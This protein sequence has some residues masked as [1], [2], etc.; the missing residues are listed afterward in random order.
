MAPDPVIHTGDV[1]YP[2]GTFCDYGEKFF[3][4]YAG[5]L[6]VAP[7]FPTVGNHDLASADGGPYDRVFAL[8]VDEPGETRRR[9][10][11]TY[12]PL[13]VVVVDSE[14]YERGDEAEIA[15]Q[16]SWLEEVLAA[17][18]DR[19]WTIVVVHHPP[20]TSLVGNDD[21][22]IRSDLAPV[23]ARYGV[24]LV[25]SGDVHAY[26][27]FHPVDGVTY[28]VTGGG[29]AELHRE[30]APGPGTT[31][32]ASVYHAVRIEAGPE[33]LVLEAIDRDGVVFDRVE[34]LADTGDGG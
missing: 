16:V 9:Y 10:A 26:E 20:F 4:P 22:V 14:V 1:V 30:L 6:A 34:L 33:Q 24:D 17:G 3:E 13:R 12:G 11:Y 31:A 23:F 5:T 29:G 27:R 15:A 21:P 28:V 32:A 2:N 8:P 19:P 7:V 18:T 25:L